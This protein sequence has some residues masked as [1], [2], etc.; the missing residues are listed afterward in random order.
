MQHDDDKKTKKSR[1]HDASTHPSE[2][3][4][5]VEFSPKINITCQVTKTLLFVAAQLTE[6]YAT[7]TSKHTL[8]AKSASQGVSG[9]FLSLS[10]V[11]SLRVFSSSFYYSSLC[12]CVNILTMYHFP[13]S[14]FSNNKGIFFTHKK[15]AIPLYLY[16]R[17]H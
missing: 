14:S 6:F 15:N 7:S 5:H 3:T 16:H 1:I 11:L 8:L 13:F 10:V 12:P 17:H 4:I 2:E 9:F